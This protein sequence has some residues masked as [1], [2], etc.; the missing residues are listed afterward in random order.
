MKEEDIILKIEDICAA[1]IKETDTLSK[2]EPVTHLSQAKIQFQGGIFGGIREYRESKRLEKLINQPLIGELSFYKYAF[3]LILKAEELTKLLLDYQQI[4]DKQNAQYYTPV[5]TSINVIQKAVSVWYNISPDMANAP[6]TIG[7]EKDV[8]L[9]PTVRISIKEE[10]AK[11]DLPESLKYIKDSDDASSHG[12][13][14]GM[15]L[16]LLSAGASGLAMMFAFIL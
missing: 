9:A 6:L 16:L 14:F 15:L 3:H 1:I 11:L 2:Y 13:C 4:A 5:I 12:G 8:A 10:F 7:N